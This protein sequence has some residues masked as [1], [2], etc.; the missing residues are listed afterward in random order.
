MQRWTEH[1]VLN[2]LSELVGSLNAQMVLIREAIVLHSGSGVI[3]GRAKLDS[4][5]VDVIFDLSVGSAVTI[6]ESLTF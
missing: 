3:Q 6:A 4:D 5:P 2:A 1:F